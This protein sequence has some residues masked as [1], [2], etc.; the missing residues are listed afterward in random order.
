VFIPRSTERNARQLFMLTAFLA[1]GIP[2]CLLTACTS[3][4]STG[5]SGAGQSARSGPA[6]AA[7]AAADGPALVQRTPPGEQLRRRSS[8]LAL[9]LMTQ[10]A[11]A[12]V[13]TSYQG[14][15]MLYRWDTGGVTVLVSE[16]LHVA[17]GQTV[18][19]TMATGSSNQPYLSA[20]Q[21]GQSP[22]G[23]LGVTTTLVKLLTSHYVVSYAGLA[24][25]GNLPAQVVE[26]WRPDGTLAARFW[27]DRA[28]KLP[29]EREVFDST[30]HL[31][32]EG[33]FIDVQVGKLSQ[34]QTM[35]AAA[36]LKAAQ[37]RP[38][39]WA[40]PIAPPKLLAFSDRGWVVPPAMP[41]GLALFTGGETATH[42]GPVLDLAYSDGLYVVSV[43]EQH[44]KLAS[45]LAG[46]Q[47]IR[48]AGQ[49]VY[50]AEPD[51][52]SLTWSGHGMVYTLIA[53]APAQT[54]A[55][56]VGALPHDRPPGFWKRIS[57]GL[58]RLVGMVNPFR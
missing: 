6:P 47:K 11:E 23:V 36:Q 27:L 43:F 37:A 32:S 15:E 16:I 39:A 4:Y 17:G 25:A 56:V 34:A 24:S 53:D 1:V 50:A 58:A 38:P 9:S 19:Q 3:Q 20:D 51:Q 29:L 44:G 10:A 55:A 42:T 14:E 41:G 45:K 49:V 8:G 48:L 18:T 5:Q 2:G 12:A 21:D 46:W 31:I 28:T 13:L 30:A 35:A 26:A 52:R 40:Y 54:V 33:V 57:T 22:E 7:K